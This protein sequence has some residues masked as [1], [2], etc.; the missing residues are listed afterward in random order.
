MKSILTI[1]LAGLFSVFVAIQASAWE[2]KLIGTWLWRYDYVDQAG[3]AGFFGP[4]DL[5]TA[6]L[7]V[8]GMP[9]VNSMNGWVGARTIN[10]IQYGM[11]TGPDASLQW[12]RAELFPEIRVNSAIRLKGAYQIGSGAV[13]EYGLNTNSAAS[14]A[15]NPI[16]TGQWTLWWMEAQTPWGILIAGKRDIGWG[17]GLQEKGR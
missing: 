16:A 8:A 17:M 14:G 4:H 13:T 10:N 6:G 1:L 3:G 11:V 15:W 12:S 7:S 2:F 9:K 5:A